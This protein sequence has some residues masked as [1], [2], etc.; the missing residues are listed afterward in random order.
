MPEKKILKK[1]LLLDRLAQSFSFTAERLRIPVSQ[2]GRPLVP[3]PSVELFLES[4]KQGEIVEPGSVSG[5]EVSVFPVGP[6]FFETGPGEREKPVLV[7]NDEFELHAVARENK[8]RFQ[9]GTGE[10]PV[11]KEQFRTD[12]KGI[13]PEGR[14]AVIRGVAILDVRRIERKALPVSLLGFR[15]KVCESVRP[16][17]EISDAER[18]RK[19]CEVEENAAPPLVQHAFLH[20]K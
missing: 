4:D 10:D 19:R 20:G 1:L 6:F 15:Q 13:E 5:T 12:K 8:G 11:L 2:G 9:V 14:H 3:W 17:S 18:R 7:R 16:G